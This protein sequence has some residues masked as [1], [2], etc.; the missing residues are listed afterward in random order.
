MKIKIY[1]NGELLKDYNSDVI[2]RTGDSFATAA[3]TKDTTYTHFG[4]GE[5]KS[6][7]WAFL[8]NEVTFETVDG[9][10]IISVKQ[11]LIKTELPHVRNLKELILQQ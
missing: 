5:K 4:N 1:S 8:V 11:G 9:P 6:V 7:D 3:L 10:V 2:P